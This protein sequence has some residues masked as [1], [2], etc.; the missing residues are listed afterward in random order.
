M[1]ILGLKKAKT[2]AVRFYTKR[3]LILQLSE[4]KY[5]SARHWKSIDLYLNNAFYATNEKKEST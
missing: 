2:N 5:R 1:H 3:F 4:I